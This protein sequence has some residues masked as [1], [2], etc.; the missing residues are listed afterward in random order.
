MRSD[1]IA[2][3]LNVDASLQITPSLVDI[4]LKGID[5]LEAIL[6]RLK[7]GDPEVTDDAAYEQLIENIKAAGT[8]GAEIG[9]VDALKTL[10]EELNPFRTQCASEAT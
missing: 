6:A 7:K 10:Q 8:A 2:T 5:E 3:D 9:I 1:N 4:L